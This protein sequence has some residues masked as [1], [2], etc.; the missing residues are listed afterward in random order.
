MYL[1]IAVLCHW[2]LTVR[3]SCIAVALQRSEATIRLT[4][5]CALANLLDR[6][7]RHRRSRRDA[8]RELVDILTEFEDEDPY[9]RR[10]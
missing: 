7:D 1:H 3:V 9:I 5:H 6:P 4:R 2:T 8:M 10:G